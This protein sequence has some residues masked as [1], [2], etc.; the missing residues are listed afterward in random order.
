MIALD[1][2]ILARLV[3]KDHPQQLLAARQLVKGNACFIPLTVTLEL[4][5]VLRAAYRLERTVI[6]D[7]YDALLQVRNLHFER[8][9]AIQQAVAYYRAGMDFADALHQAGAE[10][11]EALATFDKSFAAISEKSGSAPTVR[12]IEA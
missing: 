9:P 11:C 10:G 2:N 8:E 3:C 7:T 1:T 5:W 4:E 12:L 6:G